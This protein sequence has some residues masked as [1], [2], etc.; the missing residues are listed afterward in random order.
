[1]KNWFAYSL[2]PLSLAI[3]PLSGFAAANEQPPT[4]MRILL[5]SDDGCNSQGTQQLFHALQKAGYDAWISA[6]SGNSSGT[7]TSISFDTHKTYHFSQLGKQQYCFAGTPVD[8]LLFALT[9]LMPD[10]YPD[11]VISGVNDGANFGVHQFNSGTVAAAARALRHGIPAL[12]VS[13]GY[14]FDELTRGKTVSTPKYI[15]AT[16][17][18]TVQ[19]VNKIQQQKQQGHPFPANVGLSVNYPPYPEQ[20]IKGERYVSN[21]I[22]TQPPFSYQITQQNKQKG[23]AKLQVNIQD[24]NNTMQKKIP[25]DTYLSLSHYITLTPFTGEWNGSASQLQSLE[26]YLH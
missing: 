26:K 14:R 7:G 6:P 10:H 21:E 19:L 17:N 16:V 1:M 24:L 12:A 23:E 13:V 15:P 9:A 11:L 4:K 18:Y 2:L 5:V 22:V 20:E 3:A 25:T 8:G